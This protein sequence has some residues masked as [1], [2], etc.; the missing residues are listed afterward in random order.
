MLAGCAA[1][2]VFVGHTH[3]PLDRTSG[4]VRVVNLGSVS[5]PVTADLRATYVLLNA[6]EQGYHVERRRVEY[7][8][9]AAVAALEASGNPGAPF[10]AEFLR[11]ER[12]SPWT[13]DEEASTGAGNR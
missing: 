3:V 7:D 2:L 5:N 13:R 12:R 11:G 6:D 10:I 4:G 1:D 8:R 9:A